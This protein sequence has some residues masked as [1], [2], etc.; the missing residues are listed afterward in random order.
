MVGMHLNSNPKSQ[1]TL[2][3]IQSVSRNFQKTFTRP[4]RKARHVQQ[5]IR[6]FVNSFL[7]SNKTYDS[8]L[9]FGSLNRWEDDYLVLTVSYELKDL[10]NHLDPDYVSYYYYEGQ[11]RK[12]DFY[13]AIS[14]FGDEPNDIIEG[15]VEKFQYPPGICIRHTDVIPLFEKGLPVSRR[16]WDKLFKKIYKISRTRGFFKPTEVNR[17]ANALAK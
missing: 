16:G 10:L 2:A 8:V 7:K 5:V 14:I 13:I 3:Q 12:E 17:M 4:D 9:V 15:M 11:H 1:K 6:S